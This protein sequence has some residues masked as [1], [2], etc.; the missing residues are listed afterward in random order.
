MCKAPCARAN[1]IP[2]GGWMHGFSLFMTWPSLKKCFSSHPMGPEESVLRKSYVFRMVQRYM[3]I[4]SWHSHYHIHKIM[5]LSVVNIFKGDKAKYLLNT[6][7]K[8][9]GAEWVFEFCMLV[10]QSCLTLCDP[11]DPTEEPLQACLS[12][13]FPRQKYWNGL[14]FPPP[15]DL[16]D[17][18]IEHSLLHCRL[19]LYLLSKDFISDYFPSFCYFYKVFH[20]WK[21]KSSFLFIPTCQ[22][23]G[24]GYWLSRVSFV[25]SHSCSTLLVLSPGRFFFFTSLLPLWDVTYHIR[26]PFVHSSHSDKSLSVF[27]VFDKSLVYGSNPWMTANY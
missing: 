22:G 11:T 3:W 24:R 8:A 14:P 21:T 6:H 2:P 17:P 15:G 23:I 1:L 7:I 18:G 5:E 26:H 13:E 10:A 19:I 9:V 20:I 12:V 25:L 27:L 16:P 4:S